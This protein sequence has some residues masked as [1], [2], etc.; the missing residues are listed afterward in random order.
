M[1]RVEL[2]E[3]DYE[4]AAKEMRGWVEERVEG[5]APD[6]LFLLSH[7]PVI[8]YGPRTVLDDLPADDSADT[9]GRGNWSGTW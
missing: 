8:T 6:R 3:V 7:P 1:R 2:G 9:T 5:T 4:V